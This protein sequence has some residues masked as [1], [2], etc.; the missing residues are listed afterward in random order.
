MGTDRHRSEVP[1]R[2]AAPSLADLPLSSGEGFVLSQ[3]DG[4][5]SV[6]DL[7]LITGLDGES[8]ATALERL[9]SLGLIE[10]GPV[11]R[12]G[13]GVARPAILPDRPPTEPPAEA[14]PV[15]PP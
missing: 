15:R 11:V 6:G 12:P 4:K 7:E 13:R 5:T 8:L 14:R 3:I 10:T 1:R 2:V 9:L